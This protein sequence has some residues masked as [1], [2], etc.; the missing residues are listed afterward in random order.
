M[1]HMF[2]YCSG[3]G[4]GPTGILGLEPPLNAGIVRDGYETLMIETKMRSR[5]C[6]HQS[7][8]DVCRSRD[9]NETL[10]CT[11]SLMQ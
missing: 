8:R 1:G 7:R 9:V 11:L 6:P 4:A 5:R 2:R 10:K 3:G